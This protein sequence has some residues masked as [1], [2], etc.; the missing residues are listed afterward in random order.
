MLGPM[1]RDK[2]GV[3]AA[4]VFAEMATDLYSKGSSV[5]LLSVCTLRAVGHPL[6]NHSVCTL[7]AVGQTLSVSLIFYKYIRLLQFLMTV[8]S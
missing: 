2:D 6:A 8:P 1:Y 5:G 7:R 4:A 3:S